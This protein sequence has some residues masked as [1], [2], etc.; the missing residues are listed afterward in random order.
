MIVLDTNVVSELSRARIVSG[1]QGWVDRQRRDDLHL[2]AIT[3]AEVLYG[4]ARLPPGRRQRKL[5]VE[6]VTI[7]EEVFHRRIV[8]FDGAAAGHYADI[9]VGREGRGRP[10]S[11]A[12]AQIAAI[13][14]SRG[15]LL[16]TR[17]VRDFE[18]TGVTVV[19][20]WTEGGG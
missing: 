7:L 20:P 2:T 1:V 19:D 17:N 15:A 18:D 8:P 11:R 6:M 3:V 13:C 10:I 12:D 4:V 9:V 14:R 16:A 5:E